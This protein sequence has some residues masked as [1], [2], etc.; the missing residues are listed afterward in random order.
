[1]VKVRKV[2]IS[3]LSFTLEEGADT[4]LSSYLDTLSGHYE[5]NANGK[6][7]MEGIESRISELLIDRGGKA[8]VVTEAMAREVIGIIGKPE[9]IFDDTE[10]TGEAEKPSGKKKF[11]R[12]HD[13]KMVGGVCSGLAIHF[14]TDPLWFRLFFV[15]FTILGIGFEDWIDWDFGVVFPT[16]TYCILWA[17]MPLARTTAQKCEMRG[18]SLS[19]DNIEKQVENRKEYEAKANTNNSNFLSVCL[20]IFVGFFGVIFFIVG[21]SGILALVCVVLGLSIAGIA[22]PAVIGGALGALAG[23]PVWA[24]V[25]IKVLATIVTFLPFA[26]LLYGSI[27]MIFNFK[28]PKWKPGLVMLLVWLTAVIALLVIGAVAIPGGFWNPDL[29]NSP[30]T[31]VFN[32]WI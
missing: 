30:A 17:I 29:W 11:Y 2:S 24:S 16:L 10:G 32:N 14:R 31:T 12:D 4:L 8:G 3:G 6:E 22:V 1:M 18:E 26:A 9:D 20:K 13:G 5:G 7:I 15:L 28:T 21:F 25:T 19:W 27:K 23:I